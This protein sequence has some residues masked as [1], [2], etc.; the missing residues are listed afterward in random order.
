MAKKSS[1]TGKSYSVGSL[2]GNLALNEQN[3][4]EGERLRSKAEACEEASEFAAADLDIAIE[5][6]NFELDIE[7]AAPGAQSYMPFQLRVV[8]GFEFVVGEDQFLVEVDSCPFIPYLDKKRICLP[9]SSWS[10][11][12]P[13]LPMC[14]RTTPPVPR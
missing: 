5:C 4:A 12:T 2:I 6:G 7:P 14:S 13:R 10:T 11:P 3:R 9:Q 1:S 8:V